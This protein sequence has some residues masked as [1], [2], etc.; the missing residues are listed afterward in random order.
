VGPGQRQSHWVAGAAV[1]GTVETAGVISFVAGAFGASEGAMAFGAFLAS[2][3]GF[4]G[5]LLGLAAMA[6]SEPPTP[7]QLYYLQHPDEKAIY[8]LR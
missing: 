8:I 2:W 4:A 7:A 1:A 5:L 3:G 6:R